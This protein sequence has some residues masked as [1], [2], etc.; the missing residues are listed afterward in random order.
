M[1]VAEIQHRLRREAA[2]SA[3]P[4]RIV[5][6]VPR[7]RALPQ[8]RFTDAGQVTAPFDSIGDHDDDD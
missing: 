8:Q 5:T 3:R 2:R 7:V 1:T 6:V 4:P